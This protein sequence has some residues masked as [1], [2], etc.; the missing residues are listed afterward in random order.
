MVITAAFVSEKGMPIY[1]ELAK[2][3][4][5]KLNRNVDVISGVSYQD[6]NLLL[7]QGII[8]IGFVCGLPYTHNFNEGNYRL[9][10]IPVMALEKGDFPDIKG[11]QDIPQKYYSYTI[12]HKDSDINNWQQLKGKSYTYNDQNSNSGY[13]MPRYKLV[14]LGAKSWEDYFSRIVV[15]GSHEESIKLVANG[16]V[17]ASSVDSLV[18]DYDRHI[19]DKDAH[20]VKIIEHLFPGGA[21]I[22]PVVISNKADKKLLTQITNE[23]TN[24]HH[25]TEGKKILDKA[26]IKR[27]DLP[28]DANYDDIR[29]MEAAAHKAG[30]RDHQ[31]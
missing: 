5:R 24:M 18:L 22:P 17:D 16:I 6:S 29:K 11:Y 12:V 20:N 9:V 10:A 28:N 30:F 15:S 21:G 3:L 1:D 7:K 31:E 4:A 19:G 26:L 8:Q 23:L 25:D 2:Y 14:Q 27:F 13:N